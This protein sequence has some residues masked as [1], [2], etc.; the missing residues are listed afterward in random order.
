MKAG[1]FRNGLDPQFQALP[2]SKLASAG[3]DWKDDAATQIKWG[4]NYIAGRR[5]I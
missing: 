4:L 1:V 2:A 5:R 3:D